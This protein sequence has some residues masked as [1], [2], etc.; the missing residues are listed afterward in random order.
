MKTPLRCRVFG[1]QHPFGAQVFASVEQREADGTWLEVR[2]WCKHCNA[3]PLLGSLWV[4]DHTARTLLAKT[5]D[6]VQ[7]AET[8]IPVSGTPA[9]WEANCRAR[10]IAKW[11]TR[12]AD[13]V[14]GKEGS[15]ADQA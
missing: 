14:M 4:Q 9:E 15:H 8:E 10:L 7:G 3:R 13:G 2:G 5:P 11:N 1:H 12:A 6:G